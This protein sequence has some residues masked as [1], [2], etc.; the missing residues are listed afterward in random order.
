[1]SQN[2][3]QENSEFE[4]LYLKERKKSSMLLVAVIVLA[5]A[6]AGS[7]I[8]AVN[9]QSNTAQ[10]PGGGSEQGFGGGGQFG[11]GGGPGMMDIASFFN[12]DG[13]VDTDR[14]D[15]MTSR[16]PS[17]AGSQFVDRM[18]EEADQAVE[19]GDITQAQADELISAFESA[20]ESSNES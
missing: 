10:L 17:G 3:K 14:I 20:M 4:E 16:F 7:L 8:W 18:Q 9:G 11:G 2:H 6:T 5:L 1:M 13:S 19:D 12:D 15:E